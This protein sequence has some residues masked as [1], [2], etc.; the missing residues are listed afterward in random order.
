MSQ[1]ALPISFPALF[2]EDNFFVADCN[3]EAHGWIMRWPNWPTHALLL[4]GEAGSGKSHLGHLWAAR[5]NAAVT[6]STAEHLQG[7]A[8]IEQITALPEKDLLHLLNRAK[9]NGYFLLLTSR[10][11]PKQ[12]PFT[13]PDLTS[14]LLALP[15]V[16]I[17]P[18]DEAALS[19]ALRKQFSDRQLKVEE[20]VIDF[21]LPRMERS[22]AAGR[23]LVEQL[24]R[25]ALA[26]Q[27]NITIPFVKRALGY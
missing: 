24:D 19:A 2:S 17:A 10:V 6:T 15:A 8:L 4:Y 14:R 23:T 25:Q 12:L 18:P 1:F 20:D 22:F 5:T 9:E 21:L 16:P 13:L 3:R 7:N 11:P 27:R 26:E